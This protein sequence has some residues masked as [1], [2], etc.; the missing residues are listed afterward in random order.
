[1]P[2]NDVDELEKNID[3]STAAFFLEPIKGEGGVIPI[4]Q[5]FI[6]KLMDLK[7]RFNFLIVVDEIQSGVGRTGKFYA[8]E[9]F[10]LKPDLVATAKALGGGLPLGAFIVSDALKDVFGPGEHGTTFG[11]NPLCC[12]AGLAT[13]GIIS[14]EDFL[15]SVDKTSNAFISMLYELK[16]EF[17]DVIEE[18]R[19]MGLM[20]GVDIAEKGPEVVTAAIDNGLIVNVTAGKTL[21]FLPPLIIT[22]DHISEAYQKLRK[23]FRAI[24]RT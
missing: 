12:A 4:S 2:F 15:L 9:R 11:G 3:Q 23:T 18:I 16:E 17:D 10:G 24:Y 14:D 21:R 8:Y 19:G 22:N 6:E 1:M 7:R 13:V 20:L 5:V